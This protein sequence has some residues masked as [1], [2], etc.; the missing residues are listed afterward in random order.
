M[1]YS[2][3]PTISNLDGFTGFQP[4]RR[5][6]NTTRLID[7][8]IQ[9]IMQGEKVRL[10]DHAFNGDIRRC[11]IE[12]AYKVRKRL[13]IEHPHLTFLIDTPEIILLDYKE[14]KITP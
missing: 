9:L 14:N 6:G 8:T 11:N 1:D 12:F 10:L 2:N 13:S 5:M 3:M 4:G 7:Y